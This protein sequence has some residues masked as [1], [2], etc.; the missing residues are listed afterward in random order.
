M[1]RAS[2]F[3]QDLTQQLTI[4][5]VESLC[6]VDEGNKKVKT[7]RHL[8]LLLVNAQFIGELLI[9]LNTVFDDVHNTVLQ[10]VFWGKC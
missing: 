1:W 3:A 5:G 6:K 4:D 7:I 10:G 9:N 2:K 8:A